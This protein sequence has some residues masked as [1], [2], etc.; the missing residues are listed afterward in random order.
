L[1]VQDGESERPDGA[2]GGGRKPLKYRR[3][4]DDLRSGIRSGE[5]EPG[6][7]LPG[8]NDLMARYQV[9]RM[10]VRQALAELQREGLAV[11]RRGSGVYVSDL[12]PIVRDELGRPATMP[13]LRGESMW[14]EAAQAGDVRVE[15]FGLR[16]ESATEAVAGALELS[17]GAPV[18]TRSR[19][20]LV[21]GRAVVL[22]TSWL[23]DALV[24]GTRA[25]RP[26]PGPGGLYAVPAELGEQPT[27]FREEVRARPASRQ[28][29][30]QM[31]LPAGSP[32]LVVRRLAR[33]ERRPVELSESVLDAAVHVLRYDLPADTGGTAGA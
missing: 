12:R 28:E 30:D 11:A 29:A 27:G 31:G 6:R 10:T 20:T 22:S 32:V 3:I 23:P 1:A 17:V 5:Y 4:A 16:L 21:D 18:W 2:T 19:R 25:T 7:P 26:D 33:A 24:D 13:W 15:E 8:E 9:A 14:R